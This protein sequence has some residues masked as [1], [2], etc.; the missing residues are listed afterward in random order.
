MIAKLNGGQEVQ[1]QKE[2]DKYIVT[3][4]GKTQISTKQIWSKYAKSEWLAKIIPM[5]CFSDELLEKEDLPK[6]DFGFIDIS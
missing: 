5:T 1:I 4:P 2:G 3:T 6:F